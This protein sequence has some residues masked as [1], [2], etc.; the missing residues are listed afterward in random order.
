MSCLRQI[1]EI[2]W[3]SLK[4]DLDIC[5]MPLDCHVAGIK[6]SFQES[7]AIQ[8]KYNQHVYAAI[9]WKSQSL[10]DWW[11]IYLSSDWWTRTIRDVGGDAFEAIGSVQLEYLFLSL[12]LSPFNLLIFFF[13][14]NPKRLKCRLI[15][16]WRASVH[17]IHF[18]RSPI[19]RTIT[20]LASLLARILLILCIFMWLRSLQIVCVHAWIHRKYG[21]CDPF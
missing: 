1:K 3:N 5:L 11:N 6:M 9:L 15:Y 19:V 8:H 18:S 21:D 10:I 7:L 17:H 16:S 4:C 20:A 13:K 12:L 2:Y 14:D